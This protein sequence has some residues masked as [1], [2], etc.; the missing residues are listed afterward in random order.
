MA[1]TY[2]HPA[3]LWCHEGT[4]TVTCA[5][6]RFEMT[7][8]ELMYTSGAST[9]EETG[10]VIPIWFADMR[11]D[12]PTRKVHIGPAW[13]DV[14]VAEFSRSLGYLKGSKTLSPEVARLFSDPAA[15]PRM[16]QAAQAHAVATVL[17]DN[18]A[19]QTALEDFAAAHNVSAR[20]LQRQFLSSTGLTFSEWRT[21]Y[22]VSSAAELLAMDFSV[23]VVANLVGFAATSSLTRAFRRQTGCTPSAYLPGTAGQNPAGT[24]P[25]IPSSTTWHRTRGDDVTLWVYKGTATLTT[26]GYCRFLGAGDTATI[27]EG[28]NTRLDIAAGSVALPLGWDDDID[29]TPTLRQ[30]VARYRSAFTVIPAETSGSDNVFGFTRRMHRARKL[31]T[32]GLKPKEV[33]KQVG[34]RTTSAFS[35]AFKG[36]HGL[37]P[38]DFQNRLVEA[39]VSGS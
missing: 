14:M 13:S 4:A 2:P 25:Q 37:S 39:A 11:I 16:P 18:P 10:L 19:D 24:P 23:A 33:S 12:G 35:R 32:T 9:V 8:G 30:V 34:F 22:R 1:Y 3:L 21:A 38:R 31:L 6:S 5:S 17:A 27:P 36:M 15:P 29:A 7:E 20:T 28:T 26:T